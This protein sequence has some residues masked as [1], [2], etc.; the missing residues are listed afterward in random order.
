M[1]TLRPDW[2]FHQ[3]HQRILLTVINAHMNLL[4]ANFWRGTHLF[5]YAKN[6]DDGQ[7]EGTQIAMLTRLY[8]RAK[9]PSGEMSLRQTAARRRPSFCAQY[10]GSPASGRAATVSAMPNW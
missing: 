4:S 8:L 10:F 3:L 6:A 1:K 7:T 9:M 2:A 5:E